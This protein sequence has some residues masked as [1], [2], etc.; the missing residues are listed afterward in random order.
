MD[1]ACSPVTCQT[2]ILLHC[3]RRC[4]WCNWDIKIQSDH[5]ASWQ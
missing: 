4:L 5:D 3:L 1:G 2:A